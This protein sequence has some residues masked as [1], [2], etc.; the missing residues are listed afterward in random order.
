MAKD[1]TVKG[2]RR[3]KAGI[4]E[5][6]EKEAAED[7]KVEEEFKALEDFKA[8]AVKEDN[9]DPK[10]DVSIAA[11]IIMHETALRGQVK[12]GCI[13]LKHQHGR[14]DGVRHRHIWTRKI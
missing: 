11:E 2:S 9:A 7:F 14:A 1:K 6:V 10:V 12:V 13:N 5:Q 4:K 3:V 8:E